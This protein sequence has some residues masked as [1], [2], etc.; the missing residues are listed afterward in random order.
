LELFS[1]Q[2]LILHLR[3]QKEQLETFRLC[4]NK[5]R[6]LVARMEVLSQMGRPGRLDDENRRRLLACG[7]NIRDQ[8]PLDSVLERDVVTNYH[9]RQI[10]KLR[11]ELLDALKR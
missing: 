11:R 9:V 2:K 6:E 1:N 3:R 4:E 10:L 5:A 7:A 8:R